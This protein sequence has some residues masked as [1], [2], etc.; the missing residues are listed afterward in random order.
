MDTTQ[1]LY[2]LPEIY[3][4]LLEV[5]EDEVGPVLALLAHH[6]VAPT[7]VLDPACGP[8][9]WLEAF[10]ARGCRVAG[11]D[12]RPAMVELASARIPGEF[13]VGDMRALAFTTGPF[14]LA[15]NLSSSVGHLS[16]DE[17]VGQHLASVRAHQEPGGVYLL[18][19]S[20]P[21]AARRRPQ[22][23]WSSRKV[24][25]LGG[26]A[27]VTYR[28]VF[29]DPAARTERIGIE[30]RTWDIPSAPRKLVETYDLR[31]FPRA[32]ITALAHA[33]GYVVADAR[34]PGGADDLLLVLRA[35]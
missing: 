19:V 29:T 28:S 20:S 7:S 5:G 17:G 12:L 13:V 30:L 35:H 32:T 31:T 24:A 10:A 34:R 23:I 8:G 6:G 16:S 3:A 9:G 4:A 22:T 11:N 15:V 2:D 33:A 1:S 25:C 14:D 27:R 26:Q 18:E 21:T